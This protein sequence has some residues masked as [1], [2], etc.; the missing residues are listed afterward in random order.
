[1]DDK[2]LT[3]Q[4]QEFLKKVI[5]KGDLLI[6]YKDSGIP[7]QMTPTFA[8]SIEKLP[9]ISYN[10][11]CVNNLSVYLA[12][13][14]M[15]EL[16][17]ANSSGKVFITVKPCDVYSV[18]QMISDAQIQREKVVIIV[19]EC[20]G[21]ISVKELKEFLKDDFSGIEIKGDTLIVQTIQKGSITLKKQDFHASK[22]K[23]GSKCVLPDTND[24]FFI[25]TEKK[26]AKETSKNKLSK[27][28]TLVQDA[29]S[30]N[31][32]KKLVESELG[33][34]IRCNACRNICPACFCSDQ[35]IMD[36]PK[37]IAPFI[38]K[39]VTTKNNIL[40][41]LIR[42]YHVAPNCTACGECE[43]VCPQTIKLSIFY[44]NLHAFT[45]KELGYIPGKSDLERQKLLNYR[46][47]E[48]LV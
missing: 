3:S 12:E 39:E 15:L 32:L 17:D 31:E 41:H 2:K 22:C 16:L 35:C 19:M 23:E 27:D 48:D 4:L 34:C 47:G 36:K 33:K 26:L 25:G 24:Y 7:G 42:F 40:Y 29:L 37:L 30:K 38:D 18:L 46:F 44:K 43:R 6:S 21:V 10:P 13:L 1:M 28:S 20:D 5:K 11:F 9:T 45:E 8:R 14:N